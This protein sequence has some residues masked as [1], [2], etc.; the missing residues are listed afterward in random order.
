[1]DSWD[2]ERIFD[3]LTRQHT[4]VL[5]HTDDVESGDAIFETPTLNPILRRPDDLPLL[6][7]VDHVE[8]TCDRATLTQLD[9]DKDERA[10]VQRD[11]IDLA[12]PAAV[13]AGENDV[14]LT[15]QELLRRVFTLEAEDLTIVGHRGPRVEP[16]GPLWY[17]RRMALTAAQLHHIALLARLELSPEEEAAFAAQLDHILEHFAA[18]QQLDTGSVEPTAQIVDIETTLRDDVVRNTPNTDALLA[19]APQRDDYYFKVPKIIE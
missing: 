1:M 15:A 18:L 5:P 8:R 9:F 14:A 4:A 6:A 2:G 11:D 16:V 19:N 7:T 10:A 17:L 13:I 12:E 3:Q